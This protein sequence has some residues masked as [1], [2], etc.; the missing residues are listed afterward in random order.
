MIR[1]AA[2]AALT[3]AL[4]STT[5]CTLVGAS[6]GASIVATHNTFSSERDDGHYAI[7]MLVGAGI[8]LCV[9]VAFLIISSRAD[10]ADP[11]SE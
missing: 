4:A 1:T 7:P 8:G 9:D 3:C 6:T 2:A 11:A 10:D 5:G